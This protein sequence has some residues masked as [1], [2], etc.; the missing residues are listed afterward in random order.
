MTSNYDINLRDKMNTE[1]LNRLY[2]ELFDSPDAEGSAFKF[3]EREPVLVLDDFMTEFPMYKIKV[4]LAYTS[5]NYADLIGLPSSSPHRVGKAVKLRVTNPK[6]R[7]FVVRGLIL[8]G[9]TRV[10]VGMKHV[11]FDTDNYLK[12][13]ALYIQ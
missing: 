13:D 12:K 3:M 4:E 1:G 5:K 10:G 9:I 7:M 6:M 8:R 2:W 11:Y